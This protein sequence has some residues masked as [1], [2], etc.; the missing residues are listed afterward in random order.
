MAPTN[1]AAR[2]TD[3]GRFGT[4]GLLAPTMRPTLSFAA[5]TSRSAANRKMPGTASFTDCH[6]LESGSA[7]V[8]CCFMTPS[9]I[10]P[11]NVSGRLFNLPTTAAP[12]EPATNKVSTIGSRALPLLASNTPAREASTEPRIQL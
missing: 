4:F 6:E 1:T 7:N 5:G 12:Y 8:A 11:A 10:A 2:T 3:D 9:A